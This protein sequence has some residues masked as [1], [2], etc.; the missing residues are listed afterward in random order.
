MIACCGIALRSPCSAQA[1]GG[2]PWPPVRRMRR[3][4]TAASFGDPF[5]YIVPTM[6]AKRSPKSARCGSASRRRSL[7]RQAPRHRRDSETQRMG[8]SPGNGG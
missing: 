5:A 6:R 4:P 1:L 7:V 3:T 2:L 8:D